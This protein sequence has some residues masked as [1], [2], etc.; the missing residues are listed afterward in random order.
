MVQSLLA[1]D[2]ATRRAAASLAF[3][4]GTRI[5]ELRTGT[6]QSEGGTISDTAETNVQNDDA[7]LIEC[8]SAMVEALKNEQDEE[9]S[10]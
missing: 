10:E 3:N 4:V 1:E 7:W 9:I 8:A 2:V 6:E 5:W